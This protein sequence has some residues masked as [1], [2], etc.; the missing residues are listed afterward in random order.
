M[1]VDGTVMLRIH[2]RKVFVLRTFIGLRLMRF[3]LW[4]LGG[5]A[6]SAA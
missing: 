4:V 2:T 5:D 6:E 1:S 3:A